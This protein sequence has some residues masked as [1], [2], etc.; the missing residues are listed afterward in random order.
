MR[1][2][3]GCSN[4][5]ALGFPRLCWERCE[6]VASEDLLS[7]IVGV[8]EFLIDEADR[9]FD[10]LTL[11][12]AVAPSADVFGYPGGNDAAGEARACADERR[13]GTGDCKK[14]RHGRASDVLQVV[15]L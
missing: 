9:R 3:E 5:N 10:L 12:V 4:A 14:G 15:Y 8:A 11:A 13:C 1:L 7:S 6:R 2:F